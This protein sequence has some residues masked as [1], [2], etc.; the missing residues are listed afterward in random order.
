MHTA[1]QWLL[2]GGRWCCVE[3]QLAKILVPDA[4]G[5][6]ADNG[7]GASGPAM[8]SPL[9]DKGAD[10]AAAARMQALLIGGHKTEAL[11]CAPPHHPHFKRFQISIDLNGHLPG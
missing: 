5:P 1:L 6:S 11:K 3:A 7:W 10:P 4:G 8:H 9:L 2:S